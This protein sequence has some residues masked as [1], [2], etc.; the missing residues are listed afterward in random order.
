M[1]FVAPRTRY[2]CST[3]KCIIREIMVFCPNSINHKKAAD[4]LNSSYGVKHFMLSN[5]KLP[6]IADVDQFVI[7]PHDIV[8]K[9]T[10]NN[11]A[12]WCKTDCYVEQFW[13]T[14]KQNL[15]CWAK[16]LHMNFFAPWTIFAASA[17]NFMCGHDM[18]I[19]R[20][21]S[22]DLDWLKGCY[23]AQLKIPCTRSWWTGLLLWEKGNVAKH[24]SANVEK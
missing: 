13:S 17:T 24:H 9:I 7:A 2:F 19:A 16:L 5:D 11:C 18:H 22:R 3:Q 15:S 6:Y 23:I 10:P 12:M 1:K 14:W 8:L 20:H 4:I 21:C